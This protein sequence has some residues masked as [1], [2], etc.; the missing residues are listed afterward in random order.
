[1]SIAKQLQDLFK[2]GM[3]LDEAL[4]VYYAFSDKYYK[5]HTVDYATALF[6]GK[7]KEWAYKELQVWE[8]YCSMYVYKRKGE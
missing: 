5:K 4:E 2:V 1:M 3:S 8:R 7:V 6:N